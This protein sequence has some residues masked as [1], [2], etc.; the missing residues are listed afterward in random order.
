M[1]MHHKTHENLGMGTTTA[2]LELEQ[3]ATARGET[4][5]VPGLPRPDFVDFGNHET[6]GDEYEGTPEPLTDVD[7]TMSGQ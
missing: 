7:L 1:S 6:L 4:I 3:E 5:I 2:L